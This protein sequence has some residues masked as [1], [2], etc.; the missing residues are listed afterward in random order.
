[1]KKVFIITLIVFISILTL[2]LVAN[3]RE[4]PID[5]PLIEEEIM[6]E[7][8][9]TQPFQADDTSPLG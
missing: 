7:D 5:Y 1:M 9:M 3:E 8:W 6:V 2:S 4:L